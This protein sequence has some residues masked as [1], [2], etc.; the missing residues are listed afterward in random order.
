MKLRSLCLGLIWCFT[1]AVMAGGELVRVFPTDEQMTAEDFAVTRAKQIR[2]YRGHFYL[3]DQ[4]EHGVHL[5]D[6]HGN[7]QKQFGRLGEGPGEMAFPHWMTAG[8]GSL[9]VVDQSSHI[10]EFTLDGR[11]LKKIPV[12][13]FFFRFEYIDSRF[14]MVTLNPRSD[15]AYA[16]FDRGFEKIKS[17][18]DRLPE[19][20]KIPIQDNRLHLSVDDGLIYILQQYGAGFRVLQ[21]N[22]QMVAKGNTAVSPLDDP[23]YDDRW[24]FP[25]FAA[26]QGHFVANIVDRG[27]LALMVFSQAGA[28]VKRIRIPLALPEVKPS[29]KLYFIDM[30]IFPHQGNHYLAAAL[31]APISTV[32][33]VRLDL[34][35]PESRP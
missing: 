20:T 19:P 32:V 3:L 6:F 7:Y 34:D 27:H 29:E 25:T 13:D 31:L 1:Q 14:F 28:L 23:N 2:F 24:I 8:E 17:F 26:Y 21:P 22:G 11:F 12:I 9:F 10:H 33:L 35:W 16:T 5:F 15:F 18:R 4:G 30:T